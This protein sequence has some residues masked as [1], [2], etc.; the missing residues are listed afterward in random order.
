MFASIS[1]STNGHPAL[2]QSLPAFVHGID[3]PTF[4]LLLRRFLHDQ[5]HDYDPDLPS[6]GL[7]EDQLPMFNSSINVHTSAS[8][9]FYAPSEL[10]GAGGMHRE[11]IRSTSSWYNSYER[12]D[13]VL[14]HS[15]QS[16]EDTHGP[17]AGMMVGRVL[18]FISFTHN[19]VRYP[20]A[21]IEDFE[22][23]H[24]EVDSLTGM[25]VVRPR[26][27][28]DSRRCLSLIHIDLIFRACHL[29][30]RYGNSFIPHS[31]H[32]SHSHIAFRHF[33]LNHYADYHAH[34]CI[35]R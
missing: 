24:D 11:I 31:F 20:C 10:A 3:Y 17:L 30:G 13:T 26:R 16:S 34:E 27:H 6:L 12:R 4:P 21:L 2:T 32:F 5:I 35:P 19:D 22:L 23:V 33:Y 18:R 1:S 7:L 15:P 8:A 9:V 29:I 25:W 14:Y 28:R